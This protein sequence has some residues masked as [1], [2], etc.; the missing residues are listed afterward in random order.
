MKIYSWNMF[1][2]NTRQN[3]AFNF[4][5]EADF[6]VFCLQEVPASFLK[7][8]E[9]L[10]LP[11]VSGSDSIRIEKGKWVSHYTVI[12]STHPIVKSGAIT[13]PSLR[14][15]LRTKIFETVKPK[16]YW[17]TAGK[18]SVWADID[19]PQI[20]RARVF[21]LHLTLSSPSNRRTELELVAKLFPRDF[22]AVL[23]GD[24]NVID[25][26]FF[27]S[28]NWI[29]GSSLKESHPWHN[30]REHIEERFAHYKFK[31]PLR[32]KITHG[33]SRSQLDHILVPEG[34]SVTDAAVIKK[35]Y[36]SD[37]RPVSVELSA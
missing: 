28:F 11:V 16:G 18:G 20:G 17:K 37:H 6:D 10:G 32:G 23:A 14:T 7:R 9:T 12:L 31:N 25:H 35:T 33:F 21:S 27:R 5:S 2:F 36:G 24:F 1:C 13:F 8:L 30:E 26:V 34:F 4:I 3:A 19:F 15:P 22:P 29:L